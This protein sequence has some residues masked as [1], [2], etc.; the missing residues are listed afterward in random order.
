LN[1][2][3]SNAIEVN[4]DLDAFSNELFGTP[5]EP[6][7]EKP[8]AVEPGNEDADDTSTADDTGATNDQSNDED[9]GE[10]EP[11]VSDEKPRKKSAQ[12]RISELTAAR[13]EA[14]RQAKEWEER[15]NNLI[16]N[17][18]PDKEET[19]EAP[20]ATN[21][22]GA[23]DPDELNEDGT[24]KYPLGE[25]DPNYLRDN[26]RHIFAEEREAERRQQEEE[27]RRKQIV[28]A[29]TELQVSWE[30]KLQE[31]EGREEMA[32]IREAGVNLVEALSDLEPTYGDFLATTIM[33]M[34]MG[35]E[36]F[37]HLANNV[38]EARKIADAGGIAA[39]IA[40]GALQERIR[41]SKNQENGNPKPRV[42]KAPEPPTNL[43]RGSHGR[44]ET[45]DDTDDLDA[46]AEKLFGKK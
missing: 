13:R 12:E 6:A 8:A 19:T 43:S 40:L 15:F 10:Q 26:L 42:S 1:T 34:E 37:Y 22:N 7:K 23:P 21:E 35:P 29:R 32:D 18:E 5:S 3:D 9:E 30:S 17:K 24:P 14:E 20:A 41:A 27:N 11:E 2:E 28:D 4:D 44:F 25:Y 39:T 38:D 33:G 46:F 16:K 36:V 31:A 45:P